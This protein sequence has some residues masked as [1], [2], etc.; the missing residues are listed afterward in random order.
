MVDVLTMLS[1]NGKERAQ[2]QTHTQKRVHMRRLGRLQDER[3]NY[4]SPRHSC[5]LAYI[6]A[7]IDVDNA[8]THTHTFTIQIELSIFEQQIEQPA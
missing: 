1:E 4:E 7:H 2:Q 6:L 5:G 3:S 8:S